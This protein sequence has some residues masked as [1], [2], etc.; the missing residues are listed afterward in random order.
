MV[1]VEEPRCGGV[2]AR[3]QVTTFAHELSEA[4]PRRGT[5]A[6]ARAPRNGTKPPPR[7]HTRHPANQ[8]SPDL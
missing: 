2:A 6:V 7:R 1:P 5:A 8:A 4:R 3:S